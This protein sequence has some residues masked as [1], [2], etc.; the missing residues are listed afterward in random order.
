MTSN[1]ISIT[2]QPKELPDVYCLLE[3]IAMKSVERSST[4][5][6]LCFPPAA[7]LAYS[8]TVKMKT[9]RHTEP[10]VGFSP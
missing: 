10:P 3:R 7:S 4:S 9:R 2:I 8:S 1:Q 6:V 5:F